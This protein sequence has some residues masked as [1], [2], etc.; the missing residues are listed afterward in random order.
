MNH[1]AM[2]MA[3]LLIKRTSGMRHIVVDV[4]VEEGAARTWWFTATRIIKRALSL[5]LIVLIIS[6]PAFTMFYFIA[7]EPHWLM[8]SPGMTTE[9]RDGLLEDFHADE[10]PYLQYAHYVHGS[11]VLDF[12]TS[13]RAH[14][15]Q[16]IKG[17]F[18]PAL[19]R[20]L[21]TSSMSFITEGLEDGARG[22]DS[23]GCAPGNLEGFEVGAEAILLTT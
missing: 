6:H 12:C 4:V 5:L 11:L 23:F 8:T 19:G 3:C 20:I 10:P 9:A 1:V 22:L 14:K 15:N 2:L 7:D 13:I 17:L 16:D 18:L 21:L